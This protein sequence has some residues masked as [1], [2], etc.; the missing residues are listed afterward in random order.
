MRDN[1]FL[2]WIHDRLHHRHDAPLNADYMMRLRNI[3]ARVKEADDRPGDDRIRTEPNDLEP[4]DGNIMGDVP[5]R[6][7]VRRK[8]DVMAARGTARGCCEAHANNQSCD[9]Y[10]RALD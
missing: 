8:R 4:K 7:T 2:Q 5:S 9:C 1:E 6:P 10:E 3:I